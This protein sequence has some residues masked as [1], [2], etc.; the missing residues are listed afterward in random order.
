MCVTVCVFITAC[1]RLC[2]RHCVSPFVSSSLRVTVCVFSTACHRVS[3]SLCVQVVEV[4][5]IK[6]MCTSCCT[7]PTPPSC[8]P[9]YTATYLD[10]PLAGHVTWN[11]S[12]VG[13]QLSAGAR[14]YL[15]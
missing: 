12:A 2:L 8:L 10:G 7:Q 1:H 9:S 3:S 13:D 5:H 4:F 11:A 6:V 14:G 15:I